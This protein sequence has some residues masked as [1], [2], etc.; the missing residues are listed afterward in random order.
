MEGGRQR[1]SREA[2]ATDWRAARSEGEKQHCRREARVAK[3]WERRG[4]GMADG[5]EKKD[6]PRARLSAQGAHRTGTRTCITSIG[7][8]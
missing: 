7:T 2:E 8:G 1:G 5:G 4:H 3:A 6:G